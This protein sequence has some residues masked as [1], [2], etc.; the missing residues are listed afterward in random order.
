M[1][2]SLEPQARAH[3]RENSIAATILAQADEAGA[4]VIVVGDAGCAAWRM[5]HLDEK[6]LAVRAVTHR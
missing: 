6:A 5:R 4:S 1:R 2:A 3:V